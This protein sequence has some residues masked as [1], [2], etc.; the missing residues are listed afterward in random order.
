MFDSDVG[1]Y[2]GFTPFG[3]R[4]A[5]Y[6]NSNPQWMEYIR[7]VV[8]TYCR[9]NYEGI[10]PFIT[11]RRGERGAERVPSGPALPMTLEPLKTSMPSPSQSLPLHPSPS[12]SLPLP[13]TPCP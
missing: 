12:Q 3:E 4:N 5:Q 1:E 11:E 10:T 2:V 6:W 8:D 9:H 7:T 13:P